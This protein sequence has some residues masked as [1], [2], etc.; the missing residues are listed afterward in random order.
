M[1]HVINLMVTFDLDTRKLSLYNNE[2]IFVEL[3]KPASRLLI[4]L[5][6]NNRQNVSRDALMKSV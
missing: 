1:K 2:D 5:I 4:E 3:T 6:K